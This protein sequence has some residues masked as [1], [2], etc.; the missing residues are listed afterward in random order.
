MNNKEQQFY[1]WLAGEDV[2]FPYFQ[3]PFEIKIKVE[4]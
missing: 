3:E 2:E 1:S 4:Y